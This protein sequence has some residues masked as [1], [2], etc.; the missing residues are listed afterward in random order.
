M[1]S[2]FLAQ[3]APELEQIKDPGFAQWVVYLLL[4]ITVVD[5]LRAWFTPPPR[6]VSG[7]I[8]TSE[9]EQH[10]TIKELASLKQEFESFKETNH[11]EHRAAI[12]AGERRVAAIAEAM[13]S[14]TSELESKLDSLREKI[15]DHLDQRFEQIQARL[16]PLADMAARHDA[17][18]PQMEKRLTELADRHNKAVSGI[19]DRIN[20]VMRA[21]A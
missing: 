7:E 19:H 21:R 14:E 2:A 10:A 1:F 3:T 5:R 12:T 15:F 8:V 9:K 6:K 20:D 11:A 13:D 4:F 16:L 18:L 17:T